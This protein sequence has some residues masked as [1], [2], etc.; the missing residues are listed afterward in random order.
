MIYLFGFYLPSSLLFFLSFFL[1][2][3]RERKSFRESESDHDIEPS[4]NITWVG[5][6]MGHIHAE[7]F[8]HWAILLVHFHHF[9]RT[10]NQKRVFPYDWGLKIF[11]NCSLTFEEVSSLD[12]DKGLISTF[13]ASFHLSIPE[14]K[15]LQLMELLRFDL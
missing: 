1:D 7:Q 5:R 13:T 6:N 4:F 12:C 2:N 10:D 9:H 15:K 8:T 3:D 14:K 11:K